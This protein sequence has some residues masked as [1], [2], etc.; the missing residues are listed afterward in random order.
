MVTVGKLFSVAFTAGY[1]FQGPVRVVEGCRVLHY[2]HITF[3][4][5]LVSLRLPGQ[6]GHRFREYPYRLVFPGQL[7][8]EDSLV[9]M[10]LVVAGIPRKRFIETGYGFFRLPERVLTIR[11]PDAVAFS[12]ATQA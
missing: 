4:P 3:R 12:A 11:L 10:H 2:P 1:N 5:A 6:E 8:A 7:L 9:D